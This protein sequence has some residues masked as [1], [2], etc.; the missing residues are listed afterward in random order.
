[1]TRKDDEIRSRS[2][3]G[4]SPWLYPQR[5]SSFGADHTKPLTKA[6]AVDSRVMVDVKAYTSYGPPGGSQVGSLM[7]NQDVNEC[8]CEECKGNEG[9]AS[10]YRSH[11]DLRRNVHEEWSEEQYLLCPPRVLGYILRDKQWAQLQ[12]KFVKDIDEKGS[13]E[14]WNNRLRLADEDASTPSK[15]ESKTKELLLDLVRSH[16]SVEEGK[17]KLEVD[18]IIARKGKGLVILL[19]GTDFPIPNVA[20][21]R[22]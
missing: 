4:S 21:C 12:V 13:D 11:F 3:Y 16:S 19:Y 18:D 1:M 6:T 2:S 22:C 14:A 8:N 20:A 9:L 5:Q 10:L 17:R 15:S 7:P